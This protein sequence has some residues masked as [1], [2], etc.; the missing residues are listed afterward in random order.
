MNSKIVSVVPLRV[1]GDTERRYE[2]EVGDRVTFDGTGSSDPEGADLSFEWRLVSA[3]ATSEAAISSSSQPSP[4][5]EVDAEGEFIVG[6][7]VHDGV[8]SSSED[9]AVIQVFGEGS[10]PEDTGLGE[11]EDTGLSESEDTGI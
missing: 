5:I 6:L 2:A 10:A 3:P 7:I 8:Q 4:S 1:P 11:P 9:F